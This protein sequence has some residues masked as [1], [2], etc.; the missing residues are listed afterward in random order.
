VA[1]AAATPAA[2][3]GNLSGIKYFRRGGILGG[4]SMGIDE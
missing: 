4:G 2:A 3:S 1:L